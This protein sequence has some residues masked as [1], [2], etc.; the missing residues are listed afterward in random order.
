MWRSALAALVVA[1]VVPVQAGELYRWV[2]D[3]GVV[4]F[5]DTPPAGARGVTVG[6]MPEAPRIG[7]QPTPA[8]AD[9]TS[10]A[11]PSAGLARIALL[12][13]EI[14]P[15][16][17]SRVAIRGEVKNDGGL[18]A[19]AVVVAVR[20]VEPTQGDECLTDEIAVEPSTIAP[21][22]R[23]Q[24]TAEFDHPCFLGPTNT[25]LRAEWDE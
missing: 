17:G 19:R 13:R 23:G 4:H 14:E 21:G 16:G 7:G 10:A 2:D 6:A 1:A 11:A 18:P 5:A 15:L 25:D 3:N 24:F 20:V 8:P 22:A 9:A 12:S